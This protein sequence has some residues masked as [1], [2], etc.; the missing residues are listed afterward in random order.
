L[1]VFYVRFRPSPLDYKAVSAIFLLVLA[2]LSA[3]VQAAWVAPHIV[4]ARASGGN[5]RLWHSLGS[6]LVLAQWVVAGVSLWWLTRGVVP[7]SPSQGH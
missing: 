4:T 2:A 7:V 6:A 5:L 1:L 3:A